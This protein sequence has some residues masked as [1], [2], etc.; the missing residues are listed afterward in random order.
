MKLSL[1]NTQTLIASL[2]C[3][4]LFFIYPN[5]TLSQ[6]PIL[7]NKFGI[8]IISPVPKEA[9][10][11]ASLVNQNGDWGYVTFLIQSNDRNKDKWQ[12]FFNE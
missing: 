1:K 2:I 12:E 4:T 6:E 11:A 7:N 10:D 9:S 5:I 3:V 8:H